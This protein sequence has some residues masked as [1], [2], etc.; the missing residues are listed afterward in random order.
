MDSRISGWMGAW[1]NW[2]MELESGNVVINQLHRHNVLKFG[3][4]LPIL[5]N[6]I[7]SED[8]CVD[9]TALEDAARVGYSPGFCGEL[10]LEF[11]AFAERNK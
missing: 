11:R 10:F 9:M 6:L 2:K 1:T 4:V 5:V 3:T 8:A 7:D